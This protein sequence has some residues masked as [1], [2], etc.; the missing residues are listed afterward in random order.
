VIALEGISL[1][2]AVEADL[3][4]CE[5]TWREGLN[6]YLLPLGQ[7]EIPQDNP[8]LRQ[9]HEHMLGSDP[10]LFWVA[11]RPD[12][13]SG[14]ERVVGFA[15]AVRRGS[16]WFL[17][18]LFVRPGE[19]RAGLGKALLDRVL[20]PFGDDAA[21]VVA[22]DSAQPVSNGL[23]A[24]YGIVPRMPMFS[25][26]GRPSRSDALPPLPVGVSPIRFDGSAPAE[27]DHVLEAELAELDRTVLGFDH[28]EDHAFLRRQG[29][30][31]FAYR[32]GSGHLL[33]YGYASEL[34]RLGPIAVRDADLHAPLVADLLDAVIPRGASAI[35]APG[36]AGPTME[37]LLH[38]G[39]RIEG[40]PVLLCWSRPFADFARYLPASPGLL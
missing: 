34:G 26:V 3:A 28:V 23:Y 20:P 38:A 10:D 11:T 2:P 21:L 27:R 40:F 9:L 18:M 5:G 29:R 14:E 35:W 13:E 16:V 39:L 8:A 37:M 4:A 24:S 12:D 36:H 32:D 25:L 19:Q 31:G 15:S 1:R 30:I 6:D 7:M 33:G 22:T 17:S